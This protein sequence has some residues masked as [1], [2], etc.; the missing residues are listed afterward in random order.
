METSRKDEDLADKQR[1]QLLKAL[2]LGA[3][4]QVFSF[5]GD[6]RELERLKQ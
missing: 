4:G 2:L 1:R 5:L 6:K 3:G